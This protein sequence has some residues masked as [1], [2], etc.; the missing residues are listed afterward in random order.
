[1][2]EYILRRAASRHFLECRTSVLEIRE[3]ELLGQRPFSRKG[4]PRP[5]KCG[6]RSFDKR[7]VPDVGDFRTITG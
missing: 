4:S 3:H 6:M 7:D 1:V 2:L 5:N